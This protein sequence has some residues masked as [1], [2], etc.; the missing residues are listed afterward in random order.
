[1]MTIEPPTA[2]EIRA[3]RL[4]WG[5]SHAQFAEMFNYGRR[6]TSNELEKGKIKMSG[7]AAL[8]FRMLTGEL[9]AR[10]RLKKFVKSQN[11]S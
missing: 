11:S 9:T 2:E 7:P 3:A 5:L 6:S 8:L 4:K 10:A 1:M